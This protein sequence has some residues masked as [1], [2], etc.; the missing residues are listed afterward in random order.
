MSRSSFWK[1]L[2]RWWKILTTIP[3][4]IYENKQ[5]FDAEYEIVVW[6]NW[7]C[8]WLSKSLIQD[9]SLSNKNGSIT[10]LKYCFLYKIW[11]VSVPHNAHGCLKC[12]ATFQILIIQM[13]QNCTRDAVVVYIDDLLIS[14]KNLDY[15]KQ[16]NISCQCVHE[17]D[18]YEFRSKCDFL[19]SDL[20]FLG[21]R[22]YKIGYNL[23][24]KKL[25]TLN[26]FLKLWLITKVNFSITITDLSMVQSQFAEIATPLANLMKN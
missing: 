12:P 19:A 11:S 15:Y 14:R 2:I 21:M 26:P 3:L 13:F 22:I 4:K 25:R 8:K 7:R 23:S 24:S 5:N 9:I 20:D 16:G 18:E 10:Y 17:N 1:I 6:S